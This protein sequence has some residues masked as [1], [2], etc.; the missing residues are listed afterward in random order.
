ML[1]RSVISQITGVVVN[2][3]FYGGILCCLAVPFVYRQAAAYF[4]YAEEL[5]LPLGIVLL[6]SGMAAVYILF[7]LKKIFKTIGKGNPFI[8]QNVN[9][10]RK[11]AVA[12]ALIAGVYAL[13]SIFAFTLTTGMIS[14][15]FA[16][17]ALFCLTLKDVFK[18]AV[19]YKEE[20]DL[21]V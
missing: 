2:I 1:K 17:A 7:Q 20:N 19:W 6:V 16:V 14:L 5:A 21:T 9:A 8:V 3:M 12:C 15:V 13:K 18:Q 10:L 4:Y 11:M